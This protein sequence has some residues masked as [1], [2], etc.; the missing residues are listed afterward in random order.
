MGGGKGEEGDKGKEDPS[1]AS[2][3]R[4]LENLSVKI[5]TMD[6]KFI[7]VQSSLESIRSDITTL[8]ANMVTQEIFQKLEDRVEKLESLMNENNSFNH[9]HPR[10]RF[11]V[12][13][14]LDLIPRINQSD[15]GVLKVM[16]SLIV[17][18]ALRSCAIL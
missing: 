13:N 11:Y 10:C 16:K 14:F 15:S 7:D 2:V 18:I 3:V 17:Q 1:L 12:S 5:D 8:K 9:L 6:A 4:L